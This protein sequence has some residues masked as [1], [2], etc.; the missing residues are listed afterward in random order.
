MPHARPPLAVVFVLHDEGIQHQEVMQAVRLLEAGQPL[1]AQ[2]TTSYE[3]FRAR[4]RSAWGAERDR[5]FRGDAEEERE[6]EQRRENLQ[7][8]KVA[9]ERRAAL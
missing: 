9:V 6:P 8:P 7:I 1:T 4:V 5:I 2:T 3:P